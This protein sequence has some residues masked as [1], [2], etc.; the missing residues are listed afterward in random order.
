MSYPDGGVEETLVDKAVHAPPVGARR[1][2]CAVL[3][4]IPPL[5]SPPFSHAETDR[6]RESVTV[7][8]HQAGSSTRARQTHCMGG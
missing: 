4:A 1:R 3:R 8:L 5:P 2:S 7:S 6:G